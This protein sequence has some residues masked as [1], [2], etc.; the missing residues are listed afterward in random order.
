MTIHLK[1]VNLLLFDDEITIFFHQTE[2]NNIIKRTKEVDV[3]AHKSAH[4]N[5]LKISSM[6]KKT[7]RKR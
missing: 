3:F 6:R 1:H 4:L 7:N 5:A 2:Q